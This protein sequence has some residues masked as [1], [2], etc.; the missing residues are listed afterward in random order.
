MTAIL[1]NTKIK[2]KYVNEI[3]DFLKHDH[4][5]LSK[6]IIKNYGINFFNNKFN[7]FDFDDMKSL[8]KSARNYLLLN[9]FIKFEVKLIKIYFSYLFNTLKNLINPRGFANRINVVGSIKDSN[10]ISS[11]LN[12][13]VPGFPIKVINESFNFF[14]FPMKRI[15]RSYE[16]IIFYK[17]DPNAAN[18]TISWRPNVNLTLTKNIYPQYQ[19]NDATKSIKSIIMSIIEP[20]ESIDSFIH[21]SSKHNK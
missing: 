21:K 19:T 6:L 12:D 16:A 1:N 13:M 14:I 2:S 3:N 11:L 15:Y 9:T 5:E 18:N 17:Y 4:Q 20:L 10:E 8:S 7:N